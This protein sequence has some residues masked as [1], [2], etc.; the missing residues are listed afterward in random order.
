MGTPRALALPG[1][2]TH[3]VSNPVATQ[4]AK[5]EQTGK[6]YAKETLRVYEQLLAKPLKL[7]AVQLTVFCPIGK[8]K[9]RDGRQDK[10]EIPTTSVAI[11]AAEYW[12]TFRE[13][14][15]LPI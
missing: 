3:V 15:P 7:T 14:C 5:E 2:Q 6:Q 12:K 13:D 1:A 11:G 4:V 10:A 8:L 9:G